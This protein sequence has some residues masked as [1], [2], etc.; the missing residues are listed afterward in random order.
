MQN[1]GIT[2]L[3]NCYID[4]FEISTGKFNFVDRHPKFL[5]Y[6]ARE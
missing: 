4:K 1:G 5:A 6:I 2:C 3:G